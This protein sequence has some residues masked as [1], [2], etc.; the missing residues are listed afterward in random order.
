MPI[1]ICMATTKEGKMHDYD[2]AQVY[3]KTVCPKCGGG[4]QKWF[5]E[6]G[7]VDCED[8]CDGLREEWVG[9]SYIKDALEKG[10]E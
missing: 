9:I 2:I 7:P 3:V 8:C 1:F 10:G 4:G 5:A 6:D